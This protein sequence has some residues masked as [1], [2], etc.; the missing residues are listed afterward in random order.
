MDQATAAS[1]CCLARNAFLG[2]VA[3]GERSSSGC[4]EKDSHLLSPIANAYGLKYPKLSC[5]VVVHMQSQHITGSCFKAPGKSDIC[6]TALSEQ[7]QQDVRCRLVLAGKLPVL[8]LSV[9]VLFHCR[10]SM[11]SS[12]Q[13]PSRGG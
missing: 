10:A 4:W 5:C 12:V 3:L 2:A 1:V 11:G 9:S 7:Y 13:G 6:Q 8:M